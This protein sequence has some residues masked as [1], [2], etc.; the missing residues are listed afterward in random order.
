MKKILVTFIALI[1]L[2]SVSASAVTVEFIIGSTTMA[3]VQNN[4]PDRNLETAPLLAAPYIANDRTMVPVRAVAESFDCNV[5]WDGTTRK[6]TI[7]SAD[8]EINLFIDSTTAYINSQPVTLDVAP[9]ITNDITFV[10]V[11]FVT[12]N[13][14]YNV[15]YV[16]EAKSVLI[17][18]QENVTSND[19]TVMY[20]SYDLMNYIYFLNYG[21]HPTAEAK[22]HALYYYDIEKLFKENALVIDES[23]AP[24]ASQY[25][26]CYENNF[27][28]GE[29][30][31]YRRNSGYEDAV[32]NY[33]IQNKKSDIID[34]YKAE[35]VCAKHI[36]VEDKA[37]ADKVY[38]SAKSGKDFDK[39]IKEY[40]KDPGMEANPD[41]YVF[42]KGEMVEEFEKAT[43]DLKEG[44]ISKPVQTQFGYHIIKRLPLPDMTD[45]TMSH[46]L[47]EL[48]INPI[49]EKY[50]N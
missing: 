22:A 16:P 3:K 45:T 6:V 1:L 47:E 46:L 40:G 11:R 15:S 37:T 12:E 29:Y 42:T 20:P 17:Y 50:M 10:P 28:M 35:F 30:A 23:F 41:G 18:N 39:L 25:A 31:T 2:L 13:M 26:M 8:K 44:A 24:D 14:G 19:A 32:Y 48:Y 7:T 4:T 34:A 33:L 27:L 21:V 9:Q 36:L 49:F 38:K 5:G 43:Y